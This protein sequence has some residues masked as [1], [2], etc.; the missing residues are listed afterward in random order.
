M[1]RVKRGVMTKKRHKKFIKLAKGYY[2]RK[3]NV[4]SKA[5]EQVRK[6][7]EYAYFGRKQK[8]RDF[9]KLWIIRINAAC[10]LNNI[11]YS[12]FISGLKKANVNINRK[13]LAELAVNDP[14]A[15]S[16]IVEVSKGNSLVT[17]G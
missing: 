12:K 13:Q 16:K 15:F 11:S 17:A 7:W 6:G 4:W 10:R 2:A 1:A 9:R 14:V 5:V 3:K 8:K